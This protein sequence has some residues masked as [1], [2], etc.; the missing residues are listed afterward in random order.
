M[1]RNVELVVISDVEIY[2]RLFN[3]VL[4]MPPNINYVKV[5]NGGEWD[6]GNNGKPYETFYRY[7]RAGVPRKKL[8]MTSYDSDSFTR[9]INARMS[10]LVGHTWGGYNSH[11]PTEDL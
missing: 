3:L 4:C 7:R 9:S 11:F 6:W 1:K 8:G 10:D 2:A 5:I